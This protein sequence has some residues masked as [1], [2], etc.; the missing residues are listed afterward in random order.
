MNASLRYGTSMKRSD[1]VSRYI[2]YIVIGIGV[3]FMLV[4][5]AWYVTSN[6]PASTNLHFNVFALLSAAS[7]ISN[8]VAFILISRIKARTDVLLWFSVFLLSLSGWAG[9]EMMLRLSATPAGA[10]F[11]AP[12]STISSVIMPIS[13]FMF[14]LAYT[15]TKRSLSPFI[16]P[17]LIGTSSLF[18]FVDARTK[19]F[20][21]YDP[22]LLKSSP[23]GYVIETGPAY[24]L[25]SL[26]LIVLSLAT[27]ILLVRYGRHTIE[28]TVR[29]QTKL[30]V[31]AIA[32]PLIG[33]G[34]TDGILPSLNIVILPPMSVMLLTIMGVVISY[35]IRNHHFFSFTPGLIASEVLST[36]N[37]A[38]IGI[39][40]DLV[41][42]YANAGTE[43]LLGLTAKNLASS[44]LVDLLAEDWTL[45]LMKQKMFDAL[46]E[47]DFYTLDSVKFKTSF[48]KSVTTKVSITKV[49]GEGQPYGY[50]L[51]L[52]D[53][54]AMSQTKELVEQ[55]VV[56]R[57]RQLHEEQAKLWAS[58][59]SLN[60]GFA[61]ADSNGSLVIQNKVLA[62][63]FGLTGQVASLQQL[64][65]QLT[66]VDL[67]NSSKYVRDNGRSITVKEAGLGAKSLRIFIG[68][69]GVNEESTSHVIGTVLLVEDITE[70]KVMERSKDE[71]F[72]IAS[73]EL[74]TP[75]TTIKGNSSMILEYYKEILKDE[76]L[77]QMIRDMHS[78]SVRLIEIVDDFLDMTRLEQGKVSFVYEPI[79][80]AHLV[81]EVVKET[82]ASLDDKKLNLK[83]DKNQLENLPPVWADIKRLKLVLHHL[84]SNATNYTEKGGIVIDAQLVPKKDFVKIIVTDTGRGMK[85]EAQ[86]LLFRKFQQAGD[87]LLTR[88]TTRGTG[89]G[90][91]ISRMVME[92]MSGKIVLEKSALGK[93]SAFSLTVPVATANQLKMAPKSTAVIDS[94]TGLTIAT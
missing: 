91:Y 53:I 47:Q 63:V 66:D 44:N 76:D 1:K 17:I 36:M 82:K 26:W 25:L 55:E 33:G 41:L 86:Q 14:A 60:L 94:S 29:R 9:A 43:R 65:K 37:E 22:A 85:P 62:P 90:L 80:V 8:L 92:N 16:F 61:L 73:H 70:V 38:V 19:L 18:L 72:S 23:W 77:K 12:L 58:I 78:S 83:I 84:I 93:G 4:M 6:R 32:I 31:I 2:Y 24:F 89:I 46:A 5:M 20:S 69:V 13:L 67:T 40:P 10:V 15:D 59:D 42:S 71:F 30:F 48:G 21:L 39:T 74:R 50:L 56:E 79:P 34:I 35:G 88:D 27:L 87:S 54:T 11:W 64:Q 52:A 49:V 75:L 28:S 3:L 68:P 7:F 57:T 51:V 81:D 45:S